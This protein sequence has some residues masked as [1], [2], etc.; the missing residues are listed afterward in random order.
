MNRSAKAVALQ[1]DILRKGIRG[2]LLAPDSV[3]LPSTG[4][5]LDILHPNQGWI[6]Q[7][8]MKFGT[9]AHGQIA[10]FLQN[11]GMSF[12][13]ADIKSHGFNPRIEAALNWIQ[14]AF[15]E[16]MEVEQ[17]HQAKEGFVGRPDLVGIGR[18]SLVIISCDYKFTD[19]LTPRYF[20]QA[21]AYGH[22][23]SKSLR[24]LLQIRSN[25]KVVP[26]FWSTKDQRGHGLGFLGA[27]SVIRWRL[28]YR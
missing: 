14:K 22:F 19:S 3:F 25:G 15:S 21:E 23:Y 27:L 12:F 8:D 26:W 13:D 9:F 1:E 20:C 10:N 2:S 6:Q 28:T 4:A 11:K 16:V 7:D 24:L 5:V 18:E 17:L